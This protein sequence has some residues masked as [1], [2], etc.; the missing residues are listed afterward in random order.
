MRFLY[1]AALAVGLLI[2]SGLTAWLSYPLWD[3]MGP[4]RSLPNEPAPASFDLTDNEYA[5]A[6][7]AALELI[8]AHR[9]RHGFPAITAAVSVE[10]ELVWAGAAGWADLDGL[11]P[12]T[13]ATVFRIGSTSKAVTATALAR[14]IDAGRMDLDAPISDWRE[15]WPNPA[16]TG[17][18]P[19]QLGS[20]T[21]GLPEYSNNT[22]RAGQYLT[23]CGC[24][25]FDAVID[26]LEIFDS[27]E[28]L[29]EPGESFSYSSFDV[30]MLGA[31]IAGAQGGGYFDAL[32][33]RVFDPLGLEATGGDGDGAFRPDL[34]VF[35][36]TRSGEA[37]AEARIWRD[38]DLSQR[39]PGGGLVST[40]AELVRIGGAWLDE[41][42]IS[43]PTREAMWTPQ[44]LND[45]SV[46]EQSYAIG[47]RFYPDATWPGD[48]ARPLPYAHHGGVSKGA[49]SW[50]VV[51]PDYGLSIAVNINTRAETFGTF[52]AVEDEIAA[53]FLARIAALEEAG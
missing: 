27:A 14:M 7:V 33:A 21:A 19:R 50:L 43:A 36:E 3:G 6:G 28:L 46:N 44:R 37:G 1:A 22:D 23:L 11:T 2:L 48:E 51:Y 24:K 17:M 49:M 15:D 30:N 38:F 10:G 4:W 35:Y 26:S 45:G 53:V 5:D 16:W 25:H 40:S 18:T 8:A 39:W 34:A 47:W 29:F 41:E 31:A 42:F 12:A 20:H 13:T 32:E 9:E 52:A